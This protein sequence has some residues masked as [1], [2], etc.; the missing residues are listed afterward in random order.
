[1]GNSE[2]AK[3]S[4][5]DPQYLT[6][7]KECEEAIV[8]QYPEWKGKGERKEDE[9]L[10]KNE[11]SWLD[12]SGVRGLKNVGNS[13]HLNSAIQCLS[14]VKPL[15]ELLIQKHSFNSN[16]TQFEKQFAE[17]LNSLWIANQYD[18]VIDPSFFKAECA[19]LEAN[20][21]GSTERNAH[22]FF[23]LLFFKLSE[24]NA[25]SNSTAKM[26]ES[27]EVSK[28]VAA[29]MS[30]IQQ[31]KGAFFADWFFG[32]FKITFTCT[33]CEKFL[34][35]FEPFHEIALSLSKTHKSLNECVSLFCSQQKLEEWNCQNCKET[36]NATKKVEIWKLPKIILFHLK[37][38]DGNDS[39]HILIDFPLTD[40]ELVPL[41]K[42]SEKEKNAKFDLFATCNHSQEEPSN[43]VCFSLHSERNKWFKFEDDRITQLNQRDLSPIKNGPFLLFYK[44]KKSF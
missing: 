7:M 31:S 15:R 25:C 2:A 12:L 14:S 17:L 33:K 26:S 9:Y 4:N 10:E 23:S 36:V 44:L 37:P 39:P 1:M 5:N 43:S 20:L 40:L 28:K 42:S 35:K 16:K 41:E 11:E 3:L 19:K 21:V 27:A 29:A 6:Y 18:K 38:S 8:S 30:S 13:S 22:T 24:K 32:L 34:E